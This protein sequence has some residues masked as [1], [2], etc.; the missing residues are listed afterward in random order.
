[1]DLALTPAKRIFSTGW[2]RS[3]R[4]SRACLLTHGE[5]RGRKPFAKKIRTQFGIEA[6]LP[7]FGD[8]VEI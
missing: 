3:R 2:H 1:M 8:H 6:A 5:V 4:Q 7:E